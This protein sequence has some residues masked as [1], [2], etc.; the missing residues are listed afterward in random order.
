[1]ILILIAIFS[2]IVTGILL[3][4]FTHYGKEILEV[5]GFVMLL[6]GVLSLLLYLPL[7]YSYVSA[8]YKADVINREYGTSYTQD[9]VFY[10]DDVIDTIREI[11][12]TRI[13]VNDNLMRGGEK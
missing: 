9:E 10:A 8:G 7:V 4:R 3:M 5:S 1:M 13:E 6:V 12:K 2:L 11:D